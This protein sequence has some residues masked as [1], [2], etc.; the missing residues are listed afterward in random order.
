METFA[1]G[2]AVAF[3]LI[4]QWFIIWECIKMKT[5]VS[6]HSETL[7]DKLGGMSELLDEAIDFLSDVDKMISQPSPVIAQ[8]GM[9]IKTALLTAFMDKMTMGFNNGTTQQ[10]ERQVYEIIEP[11]TTQT[12]TIIDEYSTIN[13]SG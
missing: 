5:H 13:P 2:L 11:E 7:Q 3:V 1:L 8:T 10:E 9:D 6:D 4:M 12:E